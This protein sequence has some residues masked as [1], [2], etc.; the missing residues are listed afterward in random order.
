MNTN[1]RVIAPLATIA[2]VAG[3]VA[4]AALLPGRGADRPPVLTLAGAGAALAAE[5]GSTSS[6]GGGYK[7]TGPLPQGTPDDAPV[8]T[9]EGSKDLSRLDKALGDGV[10][11]QQRAWWWNQCSKDLPLRDGAS[12]SDQP[13]AGCAVA[14][15]V[16]PG[17]R[18]P[19]PKPALDKD[20]VRA[21]AKPVFDAVGLD[22]AQ[23]QVQTSE[24]GGSVSLTPTAGAL[25]V[26]GWT[27]RVDVGPD[28]K[29]N[30]ASGF[31][32]APAKGDDYPLI[33]AQE[34]V[35]KL[36][37]FARADICMPAPDHKGCVEPAAPEI[38]G[39]EVGLQ[40]LS[41]SKGERV[42]VPAWLFTLKGSEEP[43]AQIAIDP[44]YLGTEPEPT[45]VPVPGGTEPGG[46]GG[47]SD[48]GTGGSVP[49]DGGTEPVPPAT[50]KPER[51]EPDPATTPPP[52][53]DQP[54]REPLAFDQAFRGS[55]ANT[56]VVQFGESGSCPRSGVTHQVK[57]TPEAIYVVL[58]ADAYP[59]ETACTAD[60]HAVKRTVKLASA[61]G[62][63]KVYDGTRNTRVT[64]S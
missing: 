35:D 15:P 18:T 62:N 13:I 31:L 12:V 24:Y 38:T 7:V 5:D 40:L 41:T 27:T 34:A 22:V 48:P 60:Y 20:A 44:A 6:R 39:G 25:R 14:S 63:R 4:A 56:V 49:P 26:S 1:T 10:M 55:T 43:L 37:G 54:R 21:K 33:T 16:A 23:A 58:E 53:A 51:P 19:A 57:E 11:L 47:G 9:L 61:L 59:P 3:I 64:L 32:G 42:L 17:E 36:P 50:G 46:G 29:I 30:N 8:W 28:L 2:A 52:P 45:D